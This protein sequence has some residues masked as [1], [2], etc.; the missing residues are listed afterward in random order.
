MAR[1]PIV[2]PAAKGLGVFDITRV[3]PWLTG[4]VELCRVPM[5]RKVS[6]ILV[7]VAVGSWS[8]H[9]YRSLADRTLRMRLVPAQRLTQRDVSYEFMNRQMVWHA[10]TVRHFCSGNRCKGADG[11]VGI[12][13]F[14]P[15]VD[16]HA[17][18]IKTV[19][20]AVVAGHTLLHSPCTCTL[21]SRSQT[22]VR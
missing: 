14:P 2:R 10:F 7:G 4:P 13:P 20:S 21:P 16:Q 15:T 3:H 11:L 6:Y 8:P 22:L 17:N 19:H 12:P 18:T 9:R 5:E 1:C